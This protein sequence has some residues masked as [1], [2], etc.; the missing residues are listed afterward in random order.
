MKKVSH[1]NVL[2]PFVPTTHM[3][4]NSE[5]LEQIVVPSIYGHYEHASRLMFPVS[6]AES[7]LG[8][9]NWAH[10]HARPNTELMVCSSGRNVRMLNLAV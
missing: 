6:L 2:S 8:H 9:E 7:S 4:V 1:S 5:L 10:T 3:S